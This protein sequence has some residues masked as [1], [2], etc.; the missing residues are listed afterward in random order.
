[1]PRNFSIGVD[2]NFF[3]RHEDNTPQKVEVPERSAHKDVPLAN[4]ALRGLPPGLAPRIL[5]ALNDRKLYFSLTAANGI[6]AWR[7]YP[8][9]DTVLISVGIT[10]AYILADY[11]SHL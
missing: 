10:V 1:M 11:L 9:S 2:P 3:T 8:P 5:S 4:A 6:L 7:G